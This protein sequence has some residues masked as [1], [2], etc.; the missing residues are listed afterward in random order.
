MPGHDDGP[1]ILVKLQNREL[2]L[3]D[4]RC[5]MDLYT[6]ALLFVVDLTLLMGI[7]DLI[8]YLCR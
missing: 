5:G 2:I 6:M 8:V 3:D 4:A 7:E 1:G